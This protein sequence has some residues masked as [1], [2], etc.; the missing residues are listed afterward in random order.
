MK[1]KREWRCFGCGYP[2]P[3]GSHASRCPNC[4][5]PTYRTTEEELSSEERYRKKLHWIRW[6]IQ[7]ASEK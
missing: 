7:R 6:N 1:E 4:G 2:D 5:K 3:H